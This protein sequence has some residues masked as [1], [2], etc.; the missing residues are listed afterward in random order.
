MS[1]WQNLLSE[2][3]GP[4][5]T[6]VLNR[7]KALNAL[8]QALLG[9]L[10]EVF[11]GLAE[12]GNVRLILLTGSGERAF[13]AGADIR[14][15]AGTDATSGRALSEQ[16]QRVFSGI[17]RC[18]KPVI[19]CLNGL[20]LGG[21]LEL[22]LACTFRIAAEGA[23]LGLPEAKLGLVPGFGGFYRLVRLVGRSAALRMVLTAESV[24]ATEALRIGL[25]D[26]VVPP[27][28]LMARAGEL[29]GS[30]AQ[31]APLALRTLLELDR[32][33]EGLGAEAAFA[34]EAEVF[35]KLCESRDKGE[36]V[37]AFLEK[38]RAVWRGE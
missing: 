37:A 30:I 35:G 31:L 28:G 4:V 2:R 20:A 33:E 24:E 23:Q 17:E 9:E 22:A 6:V 36:G 26:E 3:D 14:E 7:P 5:A 1:D 18:G 32:R 8:N 25:V 27:A 12:D 13:A 15:L 10:E 38:R 19:A 21:G 16:G 29:A 11:R 34:I